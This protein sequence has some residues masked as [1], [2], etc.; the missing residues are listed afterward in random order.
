VARPTIP[1]KPPPRLLATSGGTSGVGSTTVA[2]NLTVALA[3]LGNRALWIDGDLNRGGTGPWRRTSE[4]GS[5][6]DVLAG[7]R[8]IHEVLD[9][10]PAGIQMLSGSGAPGELP[11]ASPA[12]QARFLDELNHLGLHADVVVIDLGS[13]RNSFVRRFWQVAD[14]VLLVAGADAAAVMESYAAIKVLLAGDTEIPV[15]VA[16]NFATAG[17]AADAH[18]RIAGACRKFL[19][20]ALLDPLHLET[21]QAI[22][23]AT[24]AGRSFLWP[25]IGGSSAEQIERWAEILW[26]RIRRA[27]A[28]GA[29]KLA[30]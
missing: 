30:A 9:R 16:I 19:G 24:H 10:G 29:G 8:S 20:V 17:E 18:A 6:A 14:M 15:S 7:R 1:V 3:R 11:E 28:G 2:F 27:R 13:A 4:R 25:S 21:D 26:S 23:D 5:L 12:A 22:A